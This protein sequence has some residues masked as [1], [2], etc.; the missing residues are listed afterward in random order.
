MNPCWRKIYQKVKSR[1]I[2]IFVIALHA[3]KKEETLAK[4]CL[5]AGT[6]AEDLKIKKIACLV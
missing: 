6:I 2:P 5:I 4:K 1:L 3:K